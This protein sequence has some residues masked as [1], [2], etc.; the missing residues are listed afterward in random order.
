MK[1]YTIKPNELEAIALAASTDTTRHYLNGVLLE[2]YEGGN[3]ALVATDGHRLA[4]IRARLREQP[5]KSF[6]IALS[7]IKKIV[8]KAKAE[9]KECA[10]YAKDFVKIQAEVEGNKLTLSVILVDKDGESGSPLSSFTTKPVDGQF[11]EYRRVIPADSEFTGSM[12]VNGDYM[13]SFTAMVKLLT[14]DTHRRLVFKDTGTGV[15]AP[16]L[17]TMPANGDFLGVIMQ[18]K[19]Q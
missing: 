14:E 1:T 11:P 7:D 19:G 15:Y 13:A 16:V 18:V 2:A 5:V 6:I 10:K 3:H 4:T 8:A 17:V 9:K 12:C